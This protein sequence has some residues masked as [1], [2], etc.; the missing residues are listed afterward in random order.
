MAAHW[1]AQES[2]P[3]R[4]LSGLE[5]GSEGLGMDVQYHSLNES[6]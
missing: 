2:S 5:M 1:R 4:D 6:A 3:K